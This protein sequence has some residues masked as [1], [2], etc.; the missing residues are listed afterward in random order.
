MRVKAVDN[1]LRRLL[2]EWDAFDGKR[3]TECCVKSLERICN[4]TI[5]LL[6]NTDDARQ[7]SD[8]N[9]FYSE[10]N[11]FIIYLKEFIKRYP[12]CYKEPIYFCMYYGRD[13]HSNISP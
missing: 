12:E 13:N 3:M 10:R 7:K 1:K 4:E 8:I 6:E 9:K 5:A 2:T 11:K